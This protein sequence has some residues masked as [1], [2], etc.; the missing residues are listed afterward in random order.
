[1]NAKAP[2]ELDRINDAVLTYKPGGEVSTEPLKVIAGAPDRPLVI[3]DIEIPCYVLE[4]ETRVLSQRGMLSGVGLGRGGSKQATGVPRIAEFIGRLE[5]K[6]IETNDLSAR[7]K[8]AVEFQPPTGGRTAYGYPAILL[9]DVCDAVLAARAAGVIRSRQTIV[10]RCESLMRGFARVGLIALVDEATGYQEVRDRLALH[11]F[12]D[13]YL[14]AEQAKWA[15]RF[16]DEFYQQIFRLRGW[17]WRGMKVNRPQ[18]VGKY[19]NDIVWDRI[20]PHIHEELRNRN[21]ITESGHRRAKHHQ[22]LTNDIGH[23]A[24]RD[25]L[26]GIIAIMRVSSSWHVFQ[27]YLHTAFP[28]H[29]G[30]ETKPLNLEETDAS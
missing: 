23:P 20:A 6:G 9:A 8:S 7:L 22:W 15:K 10:T 3:G 2:T 12:L 18:V 5:E 17:Q 11:K 13:R 28:K 16:P 26:V 19:T 24:L 21:P 29:G 30:R 4:D 1:M 25:H 27:K 14:L